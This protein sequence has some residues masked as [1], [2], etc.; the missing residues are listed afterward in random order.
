MHE[1][2]YLAYI[3]GEGIGHTNIYWVSGEAQRMFKPCALVSNPVSILLHP[4]KPVILY[5][6]GSIVWKRWIEL[7]ANT[8][9]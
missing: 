1:G 7:S 6:E 5:T 4:T 3:S 8:T 2:S 9:P